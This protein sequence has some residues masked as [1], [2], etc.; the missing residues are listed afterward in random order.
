MQ[1]CIW[2]C[3]GHC[4]HYAARAAQYCGHGRSHHA[5]F[6]VVVAVVMPC[7]VLWSQSSCRAWCHGCC[8]WAAW[9]HGQGHH[10]MCGVVVVVIV[11]HLV[12]QVLSLCHIWCCSCHHR[13]VH[14]LACAV[15]MP[16]L[17]CSF[18]YCAAYGVTGT[19]IMLRL[20]L[21]LLLYRTWCCGCGRCC[22]AM[23]CRSCICCMVAVGV[24]TLCGVAVVVVALHG[25]AVMA[26]APYG[27]VEL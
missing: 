3:H 1:C 15:I 25:V 7:L 19:V 4:C 11:P 12:L 18:R 16:H 17:C 26:V 21:Q 27:I 9:C 5:M 14:G 10:A 20:V 2:Y 24:V 6:G 8:R 22:R 13:A 23:W